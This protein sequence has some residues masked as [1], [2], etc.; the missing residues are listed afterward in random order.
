MKPSLV[1]R[2]ASWWIA[3]TV[4]AG[5]FLGLEGTA[6]AAIAFVGA[7]SSKTA[8]GGASSLAI[9]KPTGVAS[10]QVEIATISLQGTAT[11]TPPGGWTQIRSTTVGTSLS[12]VSFWHVA[13]GSE[14]TTTWSFS[15]SSIAAGGIDAYSGVD[16]TSIVDA[17][18]A[19][20][21]TS[22]TNATVP[23]VTT[24]YP[25][26]LV[27]GVGSLN[28]NGTLSASA[29]TTSRYNVVNGNASG[30]GVLAE[31]VAQASAGASSVQ[32]IANSKSATAWIGQ[33]ITLK[34]ASAAGVLSVSS[35]ATPNFS[36]N[37]DSGDQT[38]TYTIPLVTIASV[39]PAPGW[40]ETI[41]SS[42][43]DTGTAKLATSASTITSPPTVSCN[44]AEANC[45][46]ATNSVSYP[47]NVPAGSGPPT[48]VKF[49]NAA[50]G[51]GAG[52]FT[53][54]PTVSVSI[55]QNSFAGTYSSTV[56]IA[57]VS[58]P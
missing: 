29:G 37:L 20:T 26:D 54:T 56:T 44:S 19:T 34:A 45:T 47:V 9:T 3:A 55:P 53:V 42:Q 50:S 18:A 40:N 21:G 58:G 22:G 49:V 16:T 39:S 36:A 1:T 57:I 31:D 52:K 5:L 4:A 33:V 48:G 14:G 35:S 30:P 46:S 23:S 51:T 6:R 10:G 11:V 43:F 38:A 2:S 13:G 27:L 32:T 24:T 8:N 17:A 7:A 12:Q 41:T 28:T 25:N 15:A